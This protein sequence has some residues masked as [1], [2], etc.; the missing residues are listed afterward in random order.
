MH[1]CGT[2]NTKGK[3]SVG[4]VIDLVFVMTEPSTICNSR[5]YDGSGVLANNM[6][7]SEV[8]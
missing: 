3:V 2:Y 6:V 5:K 7:E 4:E 1:R 8:I